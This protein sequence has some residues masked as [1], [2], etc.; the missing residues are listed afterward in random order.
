MFDMLIMAVTL[1]AAFFVSPTLLL[2]RSLHHGFW[3]S[4]ILS[5]PSSSSYPVS[6][7]PR[8]E[9]NHLADEDLLKEVK[10]MKQRFFLV[11]IHCVWYWI[12]LSNEFQVLSCTFP[13][14]VR[15]SPQSPILCHHFSHPFPCSCSFF[16]DNQSSVLTLL[17]AI[18]YSLR[19]IV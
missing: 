4:C 17:S 19:A 14:L 5:S 1:L 16:T 10:E 2:I 8:V 18:V 7:M 11:R 13:T 9:V 3:P 6:P 12:I 15:V